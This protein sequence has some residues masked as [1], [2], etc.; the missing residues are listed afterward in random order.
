MPSKLG[1]HFGGVCCGMRC[2]AFWECTRA[3]SSPLEAWQVQ[4]SL[5]SW[6]RLQQAQQHLLCVVG[7]QMLLHDLPSIKLTVEVEVKIETSDP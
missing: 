1:L 4:S 5:Q 3:A 6:V 7:S 2:V